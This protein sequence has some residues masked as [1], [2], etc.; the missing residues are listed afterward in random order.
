MKEFFQYTNNCDFWLNELTLKE[1]WIYQKRGYF[2]TP[3]FIFQ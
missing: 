1:S 2:E 3:S